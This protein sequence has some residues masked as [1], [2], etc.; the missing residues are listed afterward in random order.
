MIKP[1][2]HLN[3]I[4]AVIILS[5]TLIFISKLLISGKQKQTRKNKKWVA[6]R[7]Q[8]AV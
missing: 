5:Q 6:F 1:V 3:I 8:A 4:R 7:N 2:I